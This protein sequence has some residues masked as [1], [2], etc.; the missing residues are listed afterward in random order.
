MKVKRVLQINI[1]KEN[2]FCIIDK[3]SFKSKNV[4]N[5]GNYLIRQIFIITSHLA[6]GEEIDQE[7]QQL[8]DNINNKVDNYNKFKLNN[9]QKKQAKGKCLDKKYKPLEY[10]NRDHKYIPYDFLDYLM[11]NTDC[12]KDLGSSSSQ[13][14][15]RILDKNWKSFFASIKDYSK[16]PDKYLGRPKLP[17]YKNPEKGRF[18]LYLSNNQFKFK[19]GYLYFCWTPLKCLNNKIEINIQG[20]PMQ[21]RF[22]PRYNKYIMELVYEIEV[23]EKKVSQNRIIGIDVGLNNLA[24]VVNNI[25]KEPFA[26][27]GHPLKSI[28]QYYNKEKA[29]LQSEIKKK[30]NRYWSLRLQK[31]EDKR[32]NKIKDYMHKASKYIVDWC[33]KNNID[34]IIIGK[35]DGWKQKSNMSKKVN[36]SFI[37][38]PFTMLISQVS[39]KA[40]TY[41]MNIIES[42]ESYTS[43]TSFLDEELPIKENYN[44]SRRVYR[45][46][47]KSN[48]GVEINADINGAYQ[49]IHKVVPNIIDIIDGMG[50]IGLH[51]KIINC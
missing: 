2:E 19:E 33:V 16:N 26:I 36:Q 12:F 5:Y 7:Q 25:N 45:G 9:L 44:E 50:K 24:A 6:K 46:L 34:T 13:Q 3:L 35:N 29:R 18:P 17:K 8:L 4:Y 27:N 15:L 21:L 20:R 38:I 51:P 42:E 32:F 47:F 30:N 43:G 39:Y 40:E 1:Y 48:K 28:N 10:F 31:L 14:T 11:K 37:Q 49:I 41:G 22:L 23:Q